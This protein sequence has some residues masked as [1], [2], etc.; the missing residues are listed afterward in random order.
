MCATATV[1]RWS[2]LVKTG[3]TKVNTP[4]AVTK[5]DT[6]YKEKEDFNVRE[7]NLELVSFKEISD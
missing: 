1:M 4:K 6:I 7:L 3:H 2:K 5:K